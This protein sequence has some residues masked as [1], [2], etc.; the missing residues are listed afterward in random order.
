M[1][2]GGED[3]EITPEMVDIRISSKEGFNVGMENNSFI[4][5]NTELTAELIEEGIAREMISKVQ[6][7]RKNKDY[8]IVDRIKVYY[9]SDDEFTLA[10]KNNEEYI[11]S[12][13]LAIEFINEK[14]SVDVYSL[15]D[16]EVY[17]EIE[18]IN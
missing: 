10:I 3:K 16:H 7:L 2:I 9:Y 6:Q 14:K 15:N 11:K 13:T 8:D 4:I 12:E 18:K 5:L 17:I 1:N